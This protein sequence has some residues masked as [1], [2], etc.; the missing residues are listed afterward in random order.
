M[1]IRLSA[2][3]AEAARLKSIHGKQVSSMIRMI[4]SLYHRTYLNR[5]RT[6]NPDTGN[7]LNRWRPVIAAARL[8]EEI[9]PEREALR[10]L[11]KEGL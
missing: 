4:I 2:P 10:E 5:Y 3:I 1:P 9:A 7:E 6:L 8:S 11:V